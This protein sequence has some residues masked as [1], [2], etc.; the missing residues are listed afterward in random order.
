[1]PEYEVKLNL[2]KISLPYPPSI[3]NPN[4]R[5]H[6]APKAKAKKKYRQYCYYM[7][8]QIRPEFE[9]EKIYLEITFHPPNHRKRD[10]DN[11]IAA[12][13]AGQDGLADAWHVDDYRFSTS[14]AIGDVIKHGGVSV[15][16]DQ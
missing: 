7:A 16:I 11:M 9:N 8:K 13:K 14:Y 1:M 10:K 6:W 3:L 5:S 12:F 15:Y 2:T 4:V